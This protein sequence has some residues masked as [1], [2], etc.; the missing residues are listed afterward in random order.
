M[1]ARMFYDV[2]FEVARGDTF[3]EVRRTFLSRMSHR[4]MIR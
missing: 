2:K 1:I 4:A 3:I